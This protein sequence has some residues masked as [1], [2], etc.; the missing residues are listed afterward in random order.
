MW[1]GHSPTR[2]PR[3]VKGRARQDRDAEEDIRFN[4]APRAALAR[5]LMLRTRPERVIDPYTMGNS[6]SL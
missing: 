6:H 3:K 1:R 5:R 2:S 4:I